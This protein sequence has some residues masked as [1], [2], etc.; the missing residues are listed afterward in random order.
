MPRSSNPSVRPA[1]DNFKGSRLPH[2]GER[3]RISADRAT[4]PPVPRID[5]HAASFFFGGNR[6]GKISEPFFLYY[7]T[8]AKRKAACE[9]EMK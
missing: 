4:H 3:I 9:E 1:P 8:V 7:S 6:A 5:T 2:A